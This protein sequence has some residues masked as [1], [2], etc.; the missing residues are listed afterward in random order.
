[1]SSRKISL[2]Q[3]ESSVFSTV[4]P[5]E[6]IQKSGDLQGRKVDLSAGIVSILYLLM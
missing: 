5:G 3:K 4:S 1:M 2:A 6:E